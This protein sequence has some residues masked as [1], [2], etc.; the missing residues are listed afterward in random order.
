M[1]VYVVT[2]AA[3]G[4]GKAS[5]D[6]L[7]AEGHEVIGVDLRDVEVIGDLSTNQGRSNAVAEVLEKAQGNLDGAVFAAGIG[8][9]PN[10]D[11]F[12]KIAEV[13]YLGVVELLEGLHGAFAANGGAKIVVIGSNSTSAT[14]LVFK[15]TLKAFED[16]NIEKVVKSVKFF[17]ERGSNFI[18]AASKISV[19]YW[20][21]ENGVKKEWAGAGINMNILSPGAILTPLLERQLAS[22]EEAKA[23]KSFPVPAGGFGKPEHIAEWVYA[24]LSP[25]ADFMLGTN[26]FVDGG[27][28]AYL[29]TRDWPKA[30][31]LSRTK[32]I[33][34]KMK[35]LDY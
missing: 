1:G 14:P 5:A 10:F 35:P 17:K 3:S 6:K 20:V 32:E 9:V 31:P 21:R 7:R 34:G 33:I 12:P 22:P 16:R 2:G 23:I 13:N 8:P 26:V 24:M 18:Y 30:V 11:V 25:M 27:S 4:M 15:R 19:A 28:D 29:R